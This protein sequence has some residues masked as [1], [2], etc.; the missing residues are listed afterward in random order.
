MPMIPRN[1]VST[2]GVDPHVQA[3]L[4]DV[5][6]PLRSP[7][8]EDTPSGRC[9]RARPVA[10]GEVDRRRRVGARP[11]RPRG[12]H[13]GVTLGGRVRGAVDDQAA[14]NTMNIGSRPT[15]GW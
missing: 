15:T 3:S 9:R 8:G 2:A 4:G 11:C 14:D 10:S 5:D 12:N 13:G 6:D 1:T 7:L